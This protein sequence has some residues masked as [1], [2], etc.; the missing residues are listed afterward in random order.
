M[1][2]CLASDTFLPEV[3]GVTTVLAVMRDGLRRRGH[4]VL[5]LAPSY[6]VLTED[7]HEVR[8]LRAVPCPGYPQVRLSCPWGRGLH[9][10]LERFAPQVIHAATEGPLGLFARRHAVRRRVPLVTSF[11][12]D[13]PRYAGHY[14]G[15]GAIAPVRRYLRWFHAAARLTQTPGQ[16]SRA[17]LASLGLARVALWGR[18]VDTDF[19]RPDRRSDR[20]RQE[21]HAGQDRIVV[22]HAGRLAVEKDVDTLVAAFRLARSRLGDRALFVVAGD[23]PR[24]V[25]V[26]AAL[27]WALHFGFLPRE[28]LADL[29]ADSDIFVF[30]S[31]TETCGLVALEALA[32]GVPV[33]GSDAG[34]V[35]DNLREGITGRI[36]PAGNA[37]AFAQAVVE[38][39]QDPVQRHAMRQA[40]RAFAL[41]RDWSRELDELEACYESLA[42]SPSAVMAPSSWP[43]TTSVT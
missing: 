39:A 35:P 8:R 37:P 14:L 42:A 10:V 43:T 5:V 34:G 25:A 3:N 13:F 38:L 23:G 28:T 41:G 1:R 26:R 9:R 29:Y 6:G 30:P 11:H 2:I 21:L 24:A 19:F 4:E 7:E 31:P 12:T 16:G 36:V 27:S 33:V 32:S 17:E 15:R 40:A 20:R 18:G 22:L